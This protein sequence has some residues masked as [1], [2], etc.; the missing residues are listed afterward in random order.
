M[1]HYQ[2]LIDIF[3][4]CF[5]EQY[6][7]RL[8]HGAGEPLYL[9]KDA[10]QPFHAIYFTHDYF[11][12]ALHEIAHWLIA[13]DARRQEVDY[14]YWYIPDGRSDEEQALFQQVEV[15]PQALEWILSEA[16]AYPFHFS[17]DNLNGSY[18]AAY[19]FKVAVYEQ[20]LAY[21]SKG[22][23]KRQTLFRQA[24]SSFYGTADFL[25]PKPFQAMI[26]KISAHA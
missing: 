11:S 5:Y 1:H 25:D 8:I 16:A 24:L 21:C 2:D 4:T 15:K 10:T 9:P 13:G 17:L 26:E 14:G 23:S 22:L 20:I 12:S 6:H 19:P 7:T 18:S 3:H